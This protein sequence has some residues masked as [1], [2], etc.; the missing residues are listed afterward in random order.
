MGAGSAQAGSPQPPDLFPNAITKGLAWQEGQWLESLEA[1]T[2][3]HP[4]VPHLETCHT[5][6]T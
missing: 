3:A 5:P 6:L 1:E 2:P 4:H